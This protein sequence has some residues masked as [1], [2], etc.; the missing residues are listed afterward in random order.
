MLARVRVDGMN[1]SLPAFSCGTQ[2]ARDWRA[3]TALDPKSFQSLP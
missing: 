2:T 1:R 3:L